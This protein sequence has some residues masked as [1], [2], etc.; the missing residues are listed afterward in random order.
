MVIRKIL[1]MI[2]PREHELLI[3]EVPHYKPMGKSVME[4]DMLTRRC[5]S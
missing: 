5:Q 4:T 2:P 1:G 3:F